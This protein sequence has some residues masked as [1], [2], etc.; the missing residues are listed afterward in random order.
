MVSQWVKSNGILW[1]V[2][3]RTEL[4]ACTHTQIGLAAFYSVLLEQQPVGV[5]NAAHTSS[6]NSFCHMTRCPF[7]L[8]S[9]TKFGWQALCGSSLRDTFCDKTRWH[10][11]A[12]MSSA[13]R[14]ATEKAYNFHLIPHNW[15]LGFVAG[16]KC[17]HIHT[18]MHT[19]IHTFI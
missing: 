1:H 9:A 19:Y 13:L 8:S 5:G 17:V 14:T 7:M 12:R 16:R 11:Q 10:M 3:W 6:V 15:L 4:P 18:Y 2:N